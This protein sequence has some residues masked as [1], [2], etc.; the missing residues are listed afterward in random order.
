MTF[1]FIGGQ[2]LPG[3]KNQTKEPKQD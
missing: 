1:L 3:K 2:E